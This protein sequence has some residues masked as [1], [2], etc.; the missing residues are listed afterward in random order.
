MAMLIFTAHWLHAEPVGTKQA[1]V[2][3]VVIDALGRGGIALSGPCGF[4]PGDDPAWASAAFD[5]SNWE[6]IAIDRSWGQQ[7]HAHLTGFAWCRCN[8]TITPAPGVPPQFLLLV[9]KV[10]DAYEVYWNGALIGGNGKL[11]PPH[12]WYISEPMQAYEPGQAQHGILAVRVS[13]HD[14]CR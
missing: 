12:V 10:H 13:I 14:S 3:S 7:G 9:P 6:Q 8:I 11:P 2:A 4:H 1:P 5:S